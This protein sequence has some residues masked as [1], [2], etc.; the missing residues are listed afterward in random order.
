SRSNMIFSRRSPK[1]P[2][3]S[4]TRSQPRLK[5]SLI[6]GPRAQPSLVYRHRTKMAAG[7]GMS[8]RGTNFPL[9][10]VAIDSGRC[11]MTE[12]DAVGGGQLVVGMSDGL[13]RLE[14]SKV[15]IGM[16]AGRELLRR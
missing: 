8:V 4:L 11:L 14:A 9:L 16:E 3:H 12:L 13:E 1:K 7:D 5:W 10:L 15:E 2:P 6:N